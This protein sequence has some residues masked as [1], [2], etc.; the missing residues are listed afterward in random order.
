[1]QFLSSLK[2][3][4]FL[5]SSADMKNI[6]PIVFRKWKDIRWQGKKTIFGFGHDLSSARLFFL[7]PSYQNTKH[8][9]K[10]MY[11]NFII[12]VFGEFSRNFIIIIIFSFFQDNKE[13]TKK[14]IYNKPI[15]IYTDPEV[16]KKKSIAEEFLFCIFLS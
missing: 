5:F 14:Y 6:D 15:P 13:I 9:K 2:T 16:T 7:M 10:N 8:T 1:M 12:F 11:K 4:I 3:L